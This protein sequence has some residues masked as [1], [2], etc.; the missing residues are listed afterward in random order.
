M[1]VYAP[2]PATTAHRAKVCGPR[3]A[4]RGAACEAPARVCDLPESRLR[5]AQQA[6]ER[7]RRAS[8]SRRPTAD[9]TTVRLT[10]QTGTD[11]RTGGDVG[12]VDA[13]PNHRSP[14]HR[15][16]GE[17]ATRSS[18]RAASESVPAASDPT[19]RS[20]A[21]AVHRSDRRTRQRKPQRS[22]GKRRRGPANER[23]SSTS[24]RTPKPVAPDPDVLAAD[25][26]GGAGD[27]QVRPGTSS[28]ELLEEDPGRSSR[29]CAS[30]RCSSDRRPCPGQLP[31]LGTEGSRQTSSPVSVAGPFDRGGQL[32]VVGD[33]RRVGRAERD[34]DGA[35][36]GGDVDDPLGARAR[37]RRR[38]RRRG[39]AAPRRRC[40]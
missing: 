24:R 4:S 34:Q 16:P 3:P 35:G 2:R 7:R 37:P 26:P 17:A 29:P 6:I 40:C 20:T 33:Q 23:R 21:R 30:P 12:R 13:R 10:A 14:C 28:D 31:V 22:H 1:P 9:L 27:V 15:E 25:V 36:Q 5:R 19:T 39:S 18:D 38:G 11:L 8:P 32:V